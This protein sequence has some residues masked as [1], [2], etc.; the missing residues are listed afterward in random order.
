MT[1]AFLSSASAQ[2]E[3]LPPGVL[4]MCARA[5][6]CRDVVVVEDVAA[7]AGLAD[8]AF[9]PDCPVAGFCA[10]TPLFAGE[11]EAPLLGTLV[12]ADP[13]PRVFPPHLKQRLAELGALAA[14]QLRLEEAARRASA[15]AALYRLLA[16]HSTDTIVRGNLDGVRLYVSP[17]VH[18]LLG[19]TP[20]ELVGRR[21]VELVHPQDLPEFQALMRQIREGRIE[22]GRSEQRQRHKN[23]QWVWIEAF[24]RLTSDKTTGRRDGYVVSVRDI[25]RR[26]AAEDHL[27]HLATHDA[28]TGLANR[29]RLQQR[30][31]EERARARRT[32]AGFAV[33]CLDLDHFKQVNDV[34]GHEAGDAV[35]RSAAIRIQQASREE[36]LVARLGGDEFIVVLSCCPEPGAAAERLAE[37]L[38]EMMAQPISYRGASVEVG[39][40][41]GIAVASSAMVARGLDL[42]ELLRKGDQALYRAKA[43]GRNRFIVAPQEDADA[44]GQPP[45]PL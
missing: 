15:E 26:K 32:G 4:E 33:L 21:A 38:I 6:A 19:Y 40:S 17:A 37:R 42:D 35:L 18:S 41:V 28:L 10:A 8:V 20:E 30:L 9:G 14:A 1:A 27:A 13:M 5:A 24:I 29:S 22:R 2:A 34:Y 25:S 11:Q 7:E 43:F 16:D 39:T 36:D 12:L 3:P 31:G 44:P 45:A 23:G